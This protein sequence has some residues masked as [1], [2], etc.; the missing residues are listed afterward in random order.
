MTAKLGRLKRLE[1]I[2]WWRL[3]SSHLHAIVGLGRLKRKGGERS[4]QTRA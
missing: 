2:E 1:E 4:A 3:D